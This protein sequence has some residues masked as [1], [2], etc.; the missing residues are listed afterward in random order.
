MWNSF[1]EFLGFIALLALIALVMYSERCLE[2][3]SI[4][5]CHSKTE[6]LELKT[7]L[8]LSKSGRTKVAKRYNKFVERETE[9]KER[10]D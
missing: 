6:A 3:E 10:W 7:D 5:K 1:K 9:E 2:Q 8:C 4:T